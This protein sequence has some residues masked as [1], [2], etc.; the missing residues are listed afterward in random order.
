MTT[1]TKRTLSD[2]YRTEVT[3]KLSGKHELKQQFGALVD[4]HD[5]LKRKLE[6]LEPTNEFLMKASLTKELKAVT[7]QLEEV[8]FKMAEN[9]KDFRLSDETIEE[10]KDIY[11]EESNATYDKVEAEYQKLEEM[12]EDVAAQYQKVC[13]HKMDI[14]RLRHMYNMTHDTFMT[15]KQKTKG[16][17]SISVSRY[18]SRNVFG[19]DNESIERAKV[20]L[21]KKMREAEKGI[22]I[23]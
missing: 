5:A 13:G 14:A 2:I 1:K 3:P 9:E 21:G 19:Q 23:N 18:T 4:E 10:I 16:T 17:G 7:Q 11:R 12:L 8:S 22:K 20:L 6:Q 15:D